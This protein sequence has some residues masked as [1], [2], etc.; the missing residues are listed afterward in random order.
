MPMW[1]RV[2]DD[3]L[4]LWRYLEGDDDGRVTRQVDLRAEDGT[5]VTAASLEEV[6]RFHERSDFATMGRYQQRYGLLAEGRLA[7]FGG[8]RRGDEI[9]A[10]EFERVWLDARRALGSTAPRT[11]GC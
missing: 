8:A 9:P 4:D 7:S 2:Y 11:D 1:I 3:D 6:L 5:A 10:E